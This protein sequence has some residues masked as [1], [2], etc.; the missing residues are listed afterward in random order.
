MSLLLI[1]SHKLNHEIPT[2]SLLILQGFCL[3]RNAHSFIHSTSSVSLSILLKN[4]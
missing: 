2:N 1:K 4:F 3:W